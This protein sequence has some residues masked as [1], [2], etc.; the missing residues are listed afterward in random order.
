[1]PF[2]GEIV[3]LT[4][5]CFVNTGPMERGRPEA[6]G[7]TVLLRAGALQVV[8]AETAQSVNDPAW[9]AL[10]GIDLGEVALFCT[11]AKNHFR[12]AFGTFCGAIIDVDTPGPAPADLTGLPYRHVPAS[13]LRPAQSPHATTPP[14]RPT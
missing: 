1:M 10:H 6:V 5:G 3:R 9:A 4:D 2:S 7:R 12:A 14:R 13:F 8:V 11:K